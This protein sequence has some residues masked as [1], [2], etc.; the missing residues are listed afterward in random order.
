MSDSYFSEL[1]RRPEGILTER[2]LRERDKR[3]EEKRVLEVL[4]F[5]REREINKHDKGDYL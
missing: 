5:L 1:R 3:K 2:M 4:C